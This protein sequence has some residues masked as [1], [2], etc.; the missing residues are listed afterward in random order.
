ME[1]SHFWEKN[2]IEDS[3]CKILKILGKEIHWNK[4]KLKNLLLR[5][6]KIGKNST[7]FS[8]RDVKLL[9]KLINRQKKE[10]KIDFEA[11]SH[12]FPGKSTQTLENKYNEKYSRF[13]NLQ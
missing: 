10:N 13:Q 11:I 8:V 12:H 5:I 2:S 6:K 4:N 1:I 9:R 3:Y 7:K